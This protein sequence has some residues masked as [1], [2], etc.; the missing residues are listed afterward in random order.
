MHLQ[1]DDPYRYLRKGETSVNKKTSTVAFSNLIGSLIFLAVGIWGY[2]KTT[3][4]R[5]VKGS[6]VQPATFSQIM[7]VGMLIFSVI[8]LIQSIWNLTHMKADS[9]AAEK[10]ASLNV[11]KDKGVQY[12]LIT[13][14]L[15]IAYVALFKPLGY[16]LD[17]FLVCFIIMILIGK[18]NWLQMI[19]I[20]LLVPLCMWLLFYLLL[21]VNIPMGPLSFLRDLIDKIL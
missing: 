2:W 10:A 7:L 21:K 15:C 17:S 16:V 12:A 11:F 19:L 13:I 8:L 1:S 20:S 9:P 6:Y 3:T 5:T 14:A 4:F 18:R